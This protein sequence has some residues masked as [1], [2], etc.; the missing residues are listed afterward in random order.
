MYSPFL[1]YMMP[2]VISLIG[3]QSL[4]EISFLSGKV[5]LDLGDFLNMVSPPV[6]ILWHRKVPVMVF[7]DA[8]QV[9]YNKKLY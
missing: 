8:L 7:T 2:F 6:S 3:S 5:E 1:R 9:N 4:L